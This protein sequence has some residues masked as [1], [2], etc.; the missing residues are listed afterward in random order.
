MQYIRSLSFAFRKTGRLEVSISVCAKNK[1]ELNVNEMCKI[2][3]T[4]CHFDVNIPTGRQSACHRAARL[5]E[6]R[7]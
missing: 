6:E 7:R 4:Y 3:L 2:V 5:T 1:Y